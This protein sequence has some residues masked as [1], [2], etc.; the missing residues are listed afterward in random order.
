MKIFFCSQNRAIKKGECKYLLR[1]LLIFTVS[2]EPKIVVGNDD[3]KGTGSVFWEFYIIS[4][5][6]NPEKVQF[7]VILS[8]SP[9]SFC[10]VPP[11]FDKVQ[12]PW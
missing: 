7:W 4:H 10:V 9:P 2:D 5:K 6:F 12:R 3:K 8:D 11:G 1:Q